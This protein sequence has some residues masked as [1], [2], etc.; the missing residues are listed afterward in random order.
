MTF[1]FNAS[2]AAVAATLVAGLIGCAGIIRPVRDVIAPP[3]EMNADGS[4]NPCHGYKADAQAC[5]NAAYNGARIGRVAIGQSLQDVKAIMG[6]EPE[7]R[8]VRTQDGRSSET[9]S[10][11][12]DYA[13][14]ISTRID[15]LDL[16]V[17]AIRQEH[18]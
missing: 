16:K 12:T 15:F 3:G 17:V 2:R 10:Y 5:G 6:R 11:R 9:W 1:I 8:S 4:I 7:E 13:G 14:R 18:S